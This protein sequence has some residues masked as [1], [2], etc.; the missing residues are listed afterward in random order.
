MS[1]E[2][3]L[4]DHK[5]IQAMLIDEIAM[6]DELYENANE[7]LSKYRNDVTN[8]K[9]VFRGYLTF[10][11]GQT[12]NLISL[13]NTKLQLI[14]KL[15]KLVKQDNDIENSNKEQDSK[16]KFR[17]DYI[18]S[19]STLNS[20]VTSNLNVSKDI[21]TT[22]DVD[23]VSLES[24]DSQFDEIEQAQISKDEENREAKELVKKNLGVENKEEVSI[25]EMDDSL[26]IVVTEYLSFFYHNKI[27]NTYGETRSIGI[28]SSDIQIP[29]DISNLDPE[30]ITKLKSI[31]V[32]HPLFNEVDVVS[33]DTI[34]ESLLNL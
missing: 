11:S 12:S 3:E 18:K 29:E 33:S 20:E 10:N 9:K 8:N 4:I 19:L 2:N 27:D 23:I 28:N 34:Y 21:P 16:G 30:D 15:M 7:E 14:D 25:F 17:E 5:S 6:I 22:E 13:R 1:N 26:V 24:L 31:T 32:E